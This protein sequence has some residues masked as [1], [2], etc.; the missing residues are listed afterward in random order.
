MTKKDF[1]IA[2][3]TGFLVAFIFSD[4]LE[5]T[6]F[7]HLN[8]H[9]FWLFSLLSVAGLWFCEVIGEKFSFIHEAGKYFLIGAFAAV[10]DIKVYQISVWILAFLAGSSII[11]KSISFLVATIVKF[12][13]NKIWV[14]QKHGTDGIKRE[15]MQFFAITM[16]GMLIDVF[17]FYCATKFWQPAGIETKIWTEVSIIIAAL[18]AAIWN[19]LGYKFWVFAKPKTVPDK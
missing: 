5:T 4:F 19:F 7:S 8:W 15:I 13:G 1:V 17:I 10:I 12:G 14:F 16:G 18:F 11:S 9:L 6:K 3:I 2:A